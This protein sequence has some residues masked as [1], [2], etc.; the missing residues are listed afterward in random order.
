MAGETAV[1]RRSRPPAIASASLA[2]FPDQT[3]SPASFTTRIAVSFN[4]TSNPTYSAMVA[5]LLAAWGCSY[6]IPTLG[7]ASDRRDYPKSP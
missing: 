4:E 1:A 6:K 2:V 5:L 3:I 7:P